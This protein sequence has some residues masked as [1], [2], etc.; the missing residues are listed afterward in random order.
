MESHRGLTRG[1]GAAVRV[2][3][4]FPSALDPIRSL[5]ASWKLIA[6]APGPLIIGGLLLVV[7]DDGMHGGGQFTDTDFLRREWGALRPVVL[8]GACF[9]GI[10]FY[11]ISTWLW[12]GLPRAV[13]ET[14]ATGTTTFATLFD[15]RGRYAD[16]LLA[17]LLIG[18]LVLL[19]LV[20]F[21]GIALVA[22]LLVDQR[23]AGE[24]EAIVAGVSVALLYLPLWI[25]LVLGFSWVT[26][27]VAIEERGPVDALQRS[28][29]LASGS[30]WSLLVYWLVLFV[31]TLLGACACCIGVLFTGAWSFVSRCEAFLELTRDDARPIAPAH[32]PFESGTPAPPPAPPYGAPFNPPP[33]PPS[34][35][36]PAS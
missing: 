29:Q 30:R 24:T 5:T 6:R 18:A 4:K 2:R 19:S 3:M 10:V 13:D 20:P 14:R 26:Q 36:P 28:W 33:A 21:G 15:A 8:G 12:I 22:Y 23:V 16:M 7:T 27:A 17:R 9:L 25:Y 35:P 31:F 34:S 11:L 32:V 1:R